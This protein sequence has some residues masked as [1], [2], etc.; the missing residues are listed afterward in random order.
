M[1]IAVQYR[2]IYALNERGWWM[3]APLKL[4]LGAA[5]VSAGG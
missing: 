4:N 2:P 5:T 1:D 3:F